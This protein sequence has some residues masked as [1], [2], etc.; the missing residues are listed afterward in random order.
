MSA[1][2]KRVRLFD[3]QATII[4]GDPSDWARRRTRGWRPS[5]RET[6]R[7]AFLALATDDS[8]TAIELQF[9]EHDTGEWVYVT[10]GRAYRGQGDW[11]I[12]G[13]RFNVSRRGFLPVTLPMSSRGFDRG[14]RLSKR[15]AKKLAEREAKDAEARQNPPRSGGFGG[16]LIP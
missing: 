2:K 13:H 3:A 15:E 7:E 12:W 10:I 16:W 6:V 4:E 14:R 8:V 1:P 9:R 5:N 11:G